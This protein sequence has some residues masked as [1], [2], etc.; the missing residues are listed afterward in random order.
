MA[1][2]RV[3]FYPIAFVPFPSLLGV[4]GHC[5]SSLRKKK[6]LVNTP[7]DETAA[8][9]ML[10]F[11]TLE[12]LVRRRPPLETPP[13][14]HLNIVPVKAK[15]TYQGNQFL[16][17]YCKTRGVPLNQCGKLVVAKVCKCP[18]PS[19]FRASLFLPR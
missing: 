16:T 8:C 7:V 10:D 1:C 3:C 13:S 2:F 14:A 12:I 5:Q 15:L 18:S 4:L 6:R 19:L 17:D 11:T 9:C